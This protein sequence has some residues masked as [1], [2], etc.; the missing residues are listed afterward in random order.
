MHPFSRRSSSGIGAKE[1]QIVFDDVFDAEE[2][3]S[4]AC[5]PH[6]RHERSP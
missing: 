5:L 2:N 3:I 4:K 1:V 6:Q